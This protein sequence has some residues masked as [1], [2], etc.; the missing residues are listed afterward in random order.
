[1]ILDNERKLWHTLA[2]TLP[3]K[4]PS[5]DL[6]DCI[7]MRSIIKNLQEERLQGSK[8]RGNSILSLKQRSVIA[9]ILAHSLPQFCGSAWLCE[10]WDKGS[11]SF[12]RHAEGDRIVLSTGLQTPDLASDPDAP[13]R[14]HQYPGVF[15]LAILLLE[16]ELKKTSETAKSEQGDPITEDGEFDLNVDLEIAQKMFDD[17]QDNTLPNFKAAI[18]ACLS[19]SILQRRH[20]D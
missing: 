18:E 9:V 2:P 4:A 11:I 20:R 14:F 6:R 10:N 12:F 5:L 17:I 1:M 3:R 8:F 16:M 7:S 13:Y 19:F 15:A